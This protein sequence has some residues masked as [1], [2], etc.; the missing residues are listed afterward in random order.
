M[1]CP[2]CGTELRRSR[3][4]ASFWLCDS[5]KKKYR[6]ND[7][8]RKRDVDLSLKSSAPS[9][10]NKNLLIWVLLIFL[11]PVGILYLWISK[12]RFSTKKKCILSAIFAVWFL[13][14][15]LIPQPNTEE[16]QKVTQ[17]Q[18][19][20][21]SGEVSKTT[22]EYIEDLNPQRTAL[23]DLISRYES[24][25]ASAWTTAERLDGLSDGIQNSINAMQG[26]PSADEAIS[27]AMA[28]KGIANHYSLYLTSGDQSEIDDVESLW[29]T[30]EQQN[31]P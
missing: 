20:S 1:R 11:P 30:I 29:E 15:M 26:D 3:N 19:D 4:D 16:K 21:Q 28:L 9:K 24:G 27:Y 8:R 12:K 5:C 22:E 23:E 14:V 18:E 10:K 7:V 17:G 13:I 25:E 6:V 2:K 31:L